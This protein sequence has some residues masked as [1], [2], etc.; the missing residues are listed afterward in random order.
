MPEILIALL[1]FALAVTLFDMK[2][3]RREAAR[4]NRTITSLNSELVATRK[5]VTS[6]EYAQRARTS[7]KDRPS[8]S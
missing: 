7:P 2:H 4:L 1:F 3:Y 5:T 6:Y 8:S